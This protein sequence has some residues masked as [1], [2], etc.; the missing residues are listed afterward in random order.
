MGNNETKPAISSTSENGKLKTHTLSQ[1]LSGKLIVTKE[2]VPFENLLDYVIT[3]T[4][5]EEKDDGFYM[6]N[7]ERTITIYRKWCELLPRIRPFFAIKANPDPVL[8]RQLH[9]LGTGFDCAS[10]SEIE[11]ALSV[12]SK[13]SDIIYAHPCKKPSY[14]SI[15]AKRGV[16]MMTFDSKE[17]LFKIKELYPDAE[18]LIRFRPT[19]KDALYEVNGFKFGAAVE[20]CS[21]IL[22]VAKDLGLNIIGVS[23][24]VGTCCFNEMSFVK[25]IQSSRNIFDQAVSRLHI[26][27]CDR[28][29]IH[30]AVLSFLLQ[31]KLGFS[32]SILDIGGGFPGKDSQDALFEKMCHV[33][34]HSLEQNFPVSTGVK[35]IAEPGNYFA[36]SPFKLVTNV[37]AVKEITKKQIQGGGENPP[38]RF[39]EDD[40][41]NGYMYY[42]DDGVFGSF[43]ELLYNPDIKYTP[44]TINKTSEANY[45][46]SIWGPYCDVIDFVNRDSRLPKLS[47]GDWLYFDN[48]GA[49]TSATSSSFNGFSAE[50]Y[51]YYHITL[52]TW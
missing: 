44:L 33:I 22:A 6:M 23:F 38:M 10:K 25:S 50:K 40:P 16:S 7:M 34:N 31:E 13:P 4:E 46:S 15:A 51:K 2:N 3:N 20:D 1:S 49:Y 14:I 47:V 37:I 42:I 48:F 30:K 27:K 12:G 5:R 41:D 52:E 32:F 18:L 17:E 39:T 26:D 36:C 9:L 28:P 19:C 35:I 21:D 29:T 11:L 24:H 43:S 45:P 8:V